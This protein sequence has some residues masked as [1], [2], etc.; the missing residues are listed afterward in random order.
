MSPD[1]RGPSPGEGGALGTIDPTPDGNSRDGGGGPSRLRVREVWEE[2]LSNRGLKSVHPVNV[3]DGERTGL[4]LCHTTHGN[5]DPNLSADL[6]GVVEEHILS[7][8]G[9]CPLD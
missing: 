6:T 1:V 4:P 9:N 5:N 7:P 2:D 8:P 3:R